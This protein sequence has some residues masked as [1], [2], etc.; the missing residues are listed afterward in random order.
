[1]VGAVV[2]K[3]Y[4][5][6]FLPWVALLGGWRAAVGVALGLAALLVAPAGLYGVAGTVSLHQAWW[7]TVT[8]S[9]APNLTNPDNVSMAAF[10]AKWMGVGAAASMV[11][12]AVSGALVL[13]AALIVWRGRGMPHREALE[14]ALL[15]TLVPLISPQ[16]WDYVFLVSTPAI[17]LLANYD[18]ELP[19]VVRGVTWITIAVIGLSIYDLLGREHYRAFME[20]SAITVCFV[21]LIGVLGVLRLRRVA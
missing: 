8:V 11:A 4:G 7:E 10:A 18:V 14:G 16:G 5:V 13:F 12:A 15:L 2:V 21:V 19:W 9:T 1:L 17:A 3:P 20:W 6:L